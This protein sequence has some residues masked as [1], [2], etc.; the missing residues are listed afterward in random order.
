LVV[1][2]PDDPAFRLCRALADKRAVVEQAMALAVFL[3]GCAMW[4]LSPLHEPE[5]FVGIVIVVGALVLAVVLMVAWSKREDATMRTDDLI[6]S[7]FSTEADDTAIQ[8]AVSHRLTAIETP[9]S[10]RRLATDLRWRLKLADGIVRPS[11][12]YMRASVL[13]PLC[14]SERRVLLEEKA[15]LLAMINRLEEA[16]V[17]PQALVIL[18][19]VVTTPPALDSRGDRLAGEE[20]QRRLYSASKLMASD[21]FSR[22]KNGAKEG[23]AAPR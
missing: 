11:A 21:D 17:D 6:L 2:V 19:R 12:G 5:P 20:L 16:P 9:R 3:G 13:P 10:R 22:V 8:R 15:L 7:G 18:W 1:A 14:P 23:L 4:W